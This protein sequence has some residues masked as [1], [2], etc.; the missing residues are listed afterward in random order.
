MKKTVLAAILALSLLSSLH[1]DEKRPKIGL[2]L[3]GGG[4]LGFA[5][6][7][8]L[9]E[10]EALQIPIDYIGG[11][12]MGA[13]VAG[14]YASGMSP[15]EIE[16][17]FSE[18]DWWDVI[19]DQSP[20]QFLDYRRKLDDKRF[21]GMEFGLKKK[22][23]EFSPGM[24]FGQRFNNMLESFCMNSVGI[25]DFDQLNI[26]Y[27]AVATD[28][29]SGTSVALKSGSLALAMRASMAVPGAFTPVRIDDMVLVDGGILD[30]IPVEVVRK[31]GADI[32][33]AVDVGGTAAEQG[34]ES[35]FTSMGEIIGRT[36]ALMQRP[37]QE[38]Q[39]ALADVVIAPDL[40]GASAA[41]FEQASSI[42][43]AGR[44]A[45]KELCESLKPY[46]VDADA[47]DAYLKKQRLRNQDDIQITDIQITGNNAVSEGVIRKRVHA[48]EG[49]LDLETVRDDLSR[50]HGMGD[51]QT[52]TYSL[53]PK[54][55]GYGLEY[56]TAEKFWGPTYLHFGTKVEIATDSPALWSLLLNYTRTQLNP[57]GGELQ[58]ELE[59]GGNQ[60]RVFAE[61]Y[62]PVSKSE[63]F[64]LAPSALYSL[65][66]I[67]V[68]EDNRD[69]ADVDQRFA[70]GGLD[71]G[72]SFFEYGEARI[73]V[74]AGQA[75]VSG[76]SGGTSLS[77]LNDTIVGAT[78]R[79]RLDQLNDPIFPSSG[80]QVDFDG[81]FASQ[82]I[83][84]SET[85]SKLEFKA[86][87]PFTLGSH[88]IIPK[89][90]LGHSLGTDLPFYAQFEV[91]GLNSFAGY[92]SHQLRGNAY[93]VGSLEYR[94]RLGQLPPTLGNGIYALTR[95]DAGRVWID[96]SDVQLSDLTYGGMLGL[97]A[98][99]IIGTCTFAVG[100]AE[101]I[102]PR[103]YFLIG[104]PF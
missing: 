75:Y 8:V 97:G 101:D 46:S 56:N 83:G 74:L 65:E 76:N 55:E 99:T 44:K 14:M 69:V 48:Q 1:A 26:P 12:S 89:L 87:A 73:G 17:K 24:A 95:A 58:A 61:L 6:V 57:L 104:N 42:F 35:D 50:I 100:K 19:K 91:G 21:M 80:Y 81:L 67:S 63:H 93:G 16:R 53:N 39:L 85:F 59:V 103:V 36:Y 82:D 88:T 102:P 18:M 13:I 90:A 32:V 31:M 15:D 25:T 49:A 38:K 72:I 22:K 47:F 3:G 92:A 43:P 51:F 70:T 62:Q 23:I 34:A 27:R 37:A 28:L 71:A 96:S 7:G 41:Q 10:L 79:L 64:F 77:S 94:Y 66:K 52:V 33:I 45:A 5:H 2:V 20:H 4:A 84:S 54:P 11:T 30:N 78:L 29:R 9:Q 40:T 86:L 68:Y 98:D 60:R